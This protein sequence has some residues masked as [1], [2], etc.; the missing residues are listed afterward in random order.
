MEFFNS[1][2]HEVG[3]PRSIATWAEFWKQYG[4]SIGTAIDIISSMTEKILSTQDERRDRILSYANVA[5][6]IA[7]FLASLLAPK[8]S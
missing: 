1:S 8:S 7:A 6:A 3:T 4:Q 5:A 2:D